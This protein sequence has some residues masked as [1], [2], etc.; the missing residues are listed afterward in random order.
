MRFLVEGLM[1]VVVGL[2]TFL[3]MP[4]SV[5]ETH[6]IFRGRATWLYGPSG[7][8]TE[9]EEK[10]LVNRI[11]RDDPS[12]GDM[13][14]RQAVSLRGIWNAIADY[15][16]WPIYLVGL[17][18]HT[19]YFLSESD[20]RLAGYHSLY[21]LSAGCKLPLLDTTHSGIQRLRSKY[22][23]N[24]RIFRILC[25]REL[26]DIHYLQNVADIIFRSLLLCG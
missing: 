4:A 8:F 25:E 5:T 1:S 12:K 3:V 26:T 13:N 9:H 2:T 11:L 23:S 10:V 19:N 6:K 21:T 17:S 16:L 20:L 7:W 18:C 15:D 24:S 22:A 14:N